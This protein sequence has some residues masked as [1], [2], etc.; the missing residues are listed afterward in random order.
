MC[1]IY[2]IIGW[3]G[4][5]SFGSNVQGSVIDNIGNNVDEFGKFL[6]AVVNV[7]YMFSAG[8]SFPMLFFNCRNFVMS[9]V[10]DIMNAVQRKKIKTNSTL[11]SDDI[12]QENLIDKPDRERMTKEQQERV[13]EAVMD[14]PIDIR[15]EL[16][17][18]EKQKA[19]TLGLIFN[20][21]S[22]TMLVALVLL[23]DFVSDF[24]KWIS[25]IAG[26][27]ANSIAFILPALF[28]MFS[29]NARNKSNKWYVLS[30][31]S[32]ILGGLSLIL[33]VFS[34]IWKAATG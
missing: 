25:W 8:L 30:I 20:I 22:I 29:T 11:H 31:I 14:H 5:L 4:Y 26:I 13:S 33:N 21:V 16:T 17:D 2:L 27:A 10:V 12:N 28:Y 15:R 19:K 3:L 6:V 9:V 1:T 23:A 7:G 24:D 32:L 34:N 18:E